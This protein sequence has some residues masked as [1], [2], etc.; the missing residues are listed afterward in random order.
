MPVKARQM[1][2][3][4]VNVL[5]F[6]RRMGRHQVYTLRVKGKHVVRTLISHGV[7]D[8]GDELMGI[9]ARQMKITPPLLRSILA[10][11]MGRDEYF[12][13]LREQGLIE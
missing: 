9:M 8:I 1:D 5:G 2:R 7:R 4:L 3:I 11:E 10:G 6:E 13:C 12:D